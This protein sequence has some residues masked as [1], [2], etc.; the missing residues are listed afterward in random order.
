MMRSWENRGDAAVWDEPLYAYYLHATGIDHPGAREV[1]AAGER[2]WARVVAAITGPV[3]GG[4]S[5]FFQ[6]HMTHHLLPEVDKSWLGE[7]V[8]CFLIRE[9]REVLASYVRTRESVTLD[10]IGVVQQTEIYEAAAN[11]AGRPPPVLDARDVLTDPRGMLRALCREV[12]VSFLEAMLSWPPGPRPSDGVWAKHWY[13]G[14]EASTGFAPYV[15][16][17]ADLP[18][19]LESLVQAA[20]PHYRALYERRLK[21]A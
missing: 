19:R 8:S 16:K 1:M 2:D 7:V 18:E 11:L 3:P 10:D 15:V 21:P 9:P 5:V 4:K 13:A 12:D 20:A 17:G 14:V 6:K